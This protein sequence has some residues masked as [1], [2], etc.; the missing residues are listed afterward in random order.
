MELSKYLNVNYAATFQPQAH[1]PRLHHDRPGVQ[2]TDKLSILLLHPDVLTI[3]RLRMLSWCR[4]WEWLYVFV[5]VQPMRMSVHVVT[6]QL[7]RMSV[8]VSRCSPWEWLCLLSR[9]RPSCLYT[10][11]T[12]TSIFMGCTVTKRHSHSHGLHGDNTHS[13]SHGECH[14]NNIHRNWETAR[15]D[16]L[17]GYRGLHVDSS[18]YSRD[19][20]TDNP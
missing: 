20:P 10:V 11:A 16:A 3:Q 2:R 19:N 7:M 15:S 12:N 8:Y 14:D 5:T 17:C 4:P 9:C 18:Q 13:H 6:E 1:F